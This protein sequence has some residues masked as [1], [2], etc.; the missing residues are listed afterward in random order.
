MKISIFTTMTNPEERMDPWKEALECYNSFADEVV[1]VGEDFKEDFTWSDIGKMFTEGFQKSTGDWVIWMDIDN[2][3]HESDFKRLREFIIENKNSEAIAFPKMQIFT[4]DRFAVKSV[5]CRA[6]NKK[7]YP[8]I[9]LNGGGDLC[10]P[11]LNGRL[12]QPAEVPK[13]K[14]PIWNYD[15]VFRTKEL[16]SKDRARYAKAWKKEFGNIGNRGGETPDEAYNAWFHMVDERYRKHIHQ[17]SLDQHPK[18]IKERLSQLKDDQFGFNGFG[19]K[20][21]TKRSI[22]DN[23]ISY[24]DKFKYL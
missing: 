5:I 22:K 23:I 10:L 21:N 17:L 14:V 6:F 16:I 8:T 20:E 24:K 19:L 2:F 18:F 7:D 3:F 9:L 15:T 12:I 13:T 1:V 11:T 4:P